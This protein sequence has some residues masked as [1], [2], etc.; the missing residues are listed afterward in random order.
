MTKIKSPLPELT[1][2][3]QSDGAGDLAELAELAP[4]TSAE[5]EPEPEPENEATVFATYPAQGH[6]VP[7]A[8]RRFRRSA[9]LAFFVPA[10]AEPHTKGGAAVVVKV[11][12]DGRQFGEL[13]YTDGDQ[14]LRDLGEL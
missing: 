7:V 10:H 6:A 9:E 12:R 11:Y 5:P 2:L 1:T 8:R 4:A 3:P 13:T 14:F